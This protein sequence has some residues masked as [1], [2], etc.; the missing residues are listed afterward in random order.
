MEDL[1]EK[2]DN[3][4]DAIDNTKQVKE[5]KTVNEEIMKDKKLLDLIKKYNETYDDKI[6]KQIL[7]NKLFSDYKDKETELNILIL[8]I[9]S[10][11]K[12]ISSKGKCNI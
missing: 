7:E 12:K 5:I 1:I 3:L 6:K 8:D 2:V 9:N 10:K 4:I 11:L